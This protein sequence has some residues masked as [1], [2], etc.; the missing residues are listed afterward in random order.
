MGRRRICDL[1]GDEAASDIGERQSVSYL[2]VCADSVLIILQSMGT[3]PW[4]GEHLT[5]GFTAFINGKEVVLDAQIPASQL[6]P[7]S[8]LQVDTSAG[9]ILSVDQEDTEKSASRFIPPLNFYAAKS[10][11]KSNSALARY[12]HP[13]PPPDLLLSSSAT[14]PMYPTHWS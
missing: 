13:R 14:T 5:C 7:I 12:A 3:I 2:V 9:K 11:A 6:P 1:H 10:S 4:K 8:S